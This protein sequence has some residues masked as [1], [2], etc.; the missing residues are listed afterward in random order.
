M[1]EL[2]R[3]TKFYRIIPIMWVYGSDEWLVN[4]SV[5]RAKR[6]WEVKISGEAGREKYGLI[7]V[8]VVVLL[9]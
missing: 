3:G 8:V 9:I 4:E 5:T 6:V 1:D 2:E 7:L